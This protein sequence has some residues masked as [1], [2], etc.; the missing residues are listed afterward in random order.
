MSKQAKGEGPPFRRVAAYYRSAI[1]AGQY[2]AG[3]RLPSHASIAAE[4][5]VSIG[6]AGNAMR[7]LASEGL[8]TI[9]TGQKGTTVAPLAGAT[10][11][12]DRLRLYRGERPPTDLETVREAGVIPYGE[13]YAYVAGLLGEDDDGHVV[14]RESLFS[15][16]GRP[17][18]L[19]VTWHPVS[20][21]PAV[22]ELAVPEPIPGGEGALIAQRTKKAIHRGEDFWRARGARDLREADALSVD[23][24]T[25][26][27][28]G[29]W[30]WHA[31]SGV[32]EYGEV[33]SLADRVIRYEYEITDEPSSAP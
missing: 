25:P 1:L 13:Q 6:T 7:L 27:L 3:E 8:V 24:G 15:Q 4:H 10:T 30:L 2:G 31:E 16:G 19:V 33:C 14:R 9:G 20:L 5:G 26:I 28:A 17:V 18:E 21:L 29:A 32:V 23:I 12:A 11:A 22:P